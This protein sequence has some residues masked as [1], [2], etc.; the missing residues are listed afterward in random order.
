M[1]STNISK[2]EQLKESKNINNLKSDYF[3]IKIIEFLKTKKSLEIMK[4]NKKLQKRTN[5]SIN[6]YKDYSQLYSSIEIEL[7]IVNRY[8]KFINILD[9]E[10]KYYHIYFDNSIK[11]MQRNYLEDNEKV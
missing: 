1:N 6:N 4:Y 11:E 10:K 7:K 9:E 5:I 8:G 2:N 3:L